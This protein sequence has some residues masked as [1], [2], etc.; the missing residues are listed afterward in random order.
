MDESGIS[1]RALSQFKDR[2][3]K[4]K[5]RKSSSARVSDEDDQRRMELEEMK[6][7]RDEELRFMARK[8]TN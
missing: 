1:F 8:M 7:I 4:Y 5:N 3:Q 2:M 6:E